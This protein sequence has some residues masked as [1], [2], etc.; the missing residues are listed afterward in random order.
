MRSGTKIAD[1]GAAERPARFVRGGRMAPPLCRLAFGLSSEFV[2]IFH[3]LQNPFA[4]K[5]ASLQDLNDH[6]STRVAA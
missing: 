5:A 1:S 2:P 3:L 6:A 4:K